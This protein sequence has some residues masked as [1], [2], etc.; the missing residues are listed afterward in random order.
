M[1]PSMQC[2]GDALADRLKLLLHS[3]KSAM[4]KR[5]E[6]ATLLKEL[7]RCTSDSVIA[8]MTNSVVQVKDDTQLHVE[9]LN[10]MYANLVAHKLTT[11]G[12]NA[13]LNVFIHHLENHTRVGII[14][15]AFQRL[16]HWQPD[17]LERIQGC[18]RQIS[19]KMEVALAGCQPLAGQQHQQCV[20]RICHRSEMG[21]LCYK[22]RKLQ[23]TGAT[24]Y[25]LRELLVSWSPV[26]CARLKFASETDSFDADKSAVIDVEEF[27]FEIVTLFVNF[28]YSGK[29]DCDGISV[30]L[31]L[32][33]MGQ[34]YDVSV[35]QKLMFLEIEM[36]WAEG[37]QTPLSVAYFHRAGF[38]LTS[39]LRV[40]D[41]S[42]GH[43]H[44]LKAVG[45]GVQDFLVHGD[46]LPVSQRFSFC[47]AVDRVFE[48]N[49]TYTFAALKKATQQ[50]LLT[51]CANCHLIRFD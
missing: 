25:V 43:L 46:S 19:Q 18:R 32:A 10:G 24:L 31:E 16:Q 39:L 44:Y 1:S 11:S 6:L 28:L 3:Q 26:M 37:T 2:S 27:S 14:D 13:V 42:D 38:D 34:Y 17:I 48:N 22:R 23:V 35:L 30:R 51:S 7:T 21:E 5:V 47:F 45:F 4:D 33:R 15:R 41:L 29:V 50:T 40:S 49:P 8:E 20:L 12:K 9:F 36:E